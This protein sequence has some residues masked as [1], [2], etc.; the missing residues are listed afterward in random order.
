MLSRKIKCL[1]GKGRQ[2][3]VRV[4]CIWIPPNRKIL[5]SPCPRYKSLHQFARTGW[6]MKSIV[7]HFAK[8]PPL[9]T[10]RGKSPRDLTESRLGIDEQIVQRA[11]LSRTNKSACPYPKQNSIDHFLLLNA[12]L[13]RNI[14]A[15]HHVA[16][17]HLTRRM[18]VSNYRSYTSAIFERQPSVGSAGSTR[19]IAPLSTIDR[20][21]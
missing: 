18:S 17:F 21:A 1:V 16:D 11:E 9:S 14:N 15:I 13:R 20:S 2:R 19:G 7:L 4:S 10:G 3:C 5:S 6:T 8:P 12:A